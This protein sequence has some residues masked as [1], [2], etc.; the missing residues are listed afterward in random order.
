MVFDSQEKEGLSNRLG[1][2]RNKLQVIDDFMSDITFNIKKNNLLHLFESD[3]LPKDEKEV[4]AVKVKLES[5]L[6]DVE[7][8]IPN[9]VESAKIIRTELKYL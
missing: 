7:I 9:I 3:F 1:I 4:M 2:I 8:S 6:S 5:V